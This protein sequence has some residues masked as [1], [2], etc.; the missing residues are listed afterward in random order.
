MVEVGEPDECWVWRGYKQFGYGQSQYQGR[1]HQA[2]RL[3]FL[4]ANGHWPTPC[5]LHRCDNRACC[6]PAHLF[7]G[8]QLDNMA[9][10]VSKQRQARGE[11]HYAT[12]LTAADVR[13]IR[14]RRADGE[15]LAAL[16]RAFGVSKQAIRMIALGRTWRH[17]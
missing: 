16:G 8:T 2:H 12:H 7:E 9:D 13:A 17:V 1:I 4:L 15:T 5:C 6:N 3:A 14:S 10:K 11:S